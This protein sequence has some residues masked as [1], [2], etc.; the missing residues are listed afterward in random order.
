MGSCT[1]LLNSSSDVS[2]RPSLTLNPSP[3][4]TG[5]NS[6]WLNPEW[7]LAPY[8]FWVYPRPFPTCLKSFTKVEV[9]RVFE[10]S[11]T[12]YSNVVWYYH[13]R[14][15]GVWLDLGQ[16][17]CAWNDQGDATFLE[18]AY[19][20]ASTTPP[21]R[22]SFIRECR[23]AS[24]TKKSCFRLDHQGRAPGHHPE[25]IRRLHCCRP[26][27]ITK[28]GYVPTSG[29]WLAQARKSRFST[30]QRNGPYGNMLEI[31]DLRHNEFQPQAPYVCSTQLRG[32]WQ[33]IEPCECAAG[34]KVTR[35]KQGRGNTR[36]VRSRTSV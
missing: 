3:R 34:S 14:G 24:E 4:P 13:A 2:R 21:Q 12:S 1:T 11:E 17:L 8:G 22:S 25:L 26:Q 31:I 30:V 20:S 5:V 16:T 7:R 32:G 36:L 18:D 33:G 15:S 10:S 35:C 9:V 29:T 19:G 28:N 23:N 27:S 6:T